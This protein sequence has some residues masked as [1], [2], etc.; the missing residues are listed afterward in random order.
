MAILL[1]LVEP[2]LSL[3]ISDIQ[4]EQVGTKTALRRS[5]SV[6]KPHSTQRKQHR[7]SGEQF[8]LKFKD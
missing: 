3:C 7:S 6:K 1:V 2:V 5:E 8:L 4:R